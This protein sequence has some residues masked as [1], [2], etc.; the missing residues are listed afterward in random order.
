MPHEMGEDSQLGSACSRQPRGRECPGGIFFLKMCFNF[1]VYVHLCVWGGLKYAHVNACTYRG[2]KRALD[3]LSSYIG[4][5]YNIYLA[6]EVLNKILL[7]QTSYVDTEN[8]TQVLW[9]SKESSLPPEGSLH[10]C[11]IFLKS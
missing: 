4:Y 3:A 7:L 8:P 11:H 9:K 5:Y 1:F 2:Q 10:P 6:C